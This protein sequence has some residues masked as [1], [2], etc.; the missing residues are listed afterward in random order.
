MKIGII[1]AMPPEFDALAAPLG[2]RSAVLPGP[3]RRECFQPAGHL[4]QLVQSGIGCDNATQ[5]A[6]QLL[7]EQ[8]PDLLITS[9]FCGAILPGLKAGQ[10]VVASSIWMDG[11]SGITNIPHQISGVGLACIAGSLPHGNP[12]VKGSFITTQAIRSKKALAKSL[13][14]RSPHPVVEM[15]SGA[16]ARVAAQH[17]IPLLGI[18]AVSDTADEELDFSLDEFCDDGLRRIV[19]GNVLL[20]VV[21]RPHILPQLLRLGRSSRLAANALTAALPA[22]ISLLDTVSHR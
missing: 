15:E 22:L 11:E 20:T 6:H 21:R 19:P 4:I 10:I 1:C 16:I 13:P 3:L 7:E 5:A 9:G 14:D 8:S 12:A 2:R 18:R 17:G